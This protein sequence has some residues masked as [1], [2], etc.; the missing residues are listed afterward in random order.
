M[1]AGGVLT[2]LVERHEMYKNL[3]DLMGRIA[4]LYGTTLECL[5]KAE[6]ENITTAEMAD[7]MAEKRLND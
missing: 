5:T 3:K 2:I 6:E 1:N 7:I 4:E